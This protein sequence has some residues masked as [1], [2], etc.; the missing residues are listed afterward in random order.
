ME[1][2]EIDNAVFRPSHKPWKSI[3]PIPTFPLSRQPRD[4]YEKIPKRRRPKLPAPTGPFRLIL[5]LEKTSLVFHRSPATN[6][7]ASASRRS[8]VRLAKGGKATVWHR[9][10]VLPPDGRHEAAP[11]RAS[12]Q[13]AIRGCASPRAAWRGAG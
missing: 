12:T 2:P 5:G 7:R 6:I 9:L 8:I 10:S 13:T 4:I 1:S 11:Y 3:K